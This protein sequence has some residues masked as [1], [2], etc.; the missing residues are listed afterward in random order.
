L[1]PG[2]A[3]GTSFAVP[4]IVLMSLFLKPPPFESRAESVA[5]AIELLSTGDAKVRPGGQASCR[6]LNFRLA[7]PGRLVDVGRLSELD[8]LRAA[9]DGVAIG[10]CAGTPPAR[11]GCGARRA[12]DVPP[13]GGESRRP[14]SNPRPVGHSEAASRM[15]IR[16]PSSQSSTWIL[17]RRSS[18]KAGRPARVVPAAEFFIGPFQTTLARTSCGA[19]CA[20]PGTDIHGV[21]DFRRE[22]ADVLTRRALAR[23]RRARRH[24]VLAASRTA[25]GT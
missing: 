1:A 2:P 3:G 20:C 22:L 24:R 5:D 17:R 13:R 23:A 6:V 10:H 8:Y 25:G 18:S 11:V 14:P 4:K 7:R 19:K 16:R 9:D 21:A 15:P 12:V